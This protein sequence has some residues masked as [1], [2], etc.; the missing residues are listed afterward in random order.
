MEKKG[1]NELM[2]FG[3]TP[4][5]AVAVAFVIAVAISLLLLQSSVTTAHRTVRAEQSADSIAFHINQ[6]MAML[7]KQA[8]T[9][10]TSI[11]LTQLVTSGDGTAIA[12]EEARLRELIPSAL[13]V[14]LFPLG[15][16][17]LD[18]N[19]NPPFSF[20][21]LDMVNRV[22]TGQGVHP[23]AI[24]TNGS[25]ALSLA[26][27]IRSPSDETVRGTL[28][29]YLDMTALSAGLDSMSRGEIRLTQTFGNNPPNDI[30][31]TGDG[32]AGATLVT[33]VMNNP[34]WTLNYIPAERIASSTVGNIFLYL[35]PAIAFLLIAVAGVT[36]GI[37]TILRTVNA[38]AKHLANQM[39]DVISGEYK[40][41]NRYSLLSFADLDTNLSR[42]GKGQVKKPPVPKLDVKLQPKAKT[43]DEMV[44]IEMLDQDDYERETQSKD[45]KDS[46]GSKDNKDNAVDIREIFRAYDIRG[47]V[48][49]TLTTEVIKKI[50]LA[51]GSEA[52][53]LGE[54]ALVVGFDGRISSPDVVEALIEGLT[55]SGRDVINIGM[56]PTPVLYFAT[57]N[58]EARSGVMVTASHNPPDYNGFKIVLDGRTLVEDD[59]TRIYE[60]VMSGD[61]SSGDGRVRE[62]DVT[63]DY[64]EAIVDDVVVAQPLKVVVDCGNGVAGLLVPDLLNNLGCDVLPLY[65]DVDGHFPNHPADPL[66]PANLKDLIMMVKT[67]EAD[68]GIAFDG[69]GDRLV[70]I[71][72]SGEIVWPD[73]LMMLF[74]KDV[75]ARNPG[76][77]VV[78]DVK[79][80]RH[81]NTIISTFGGR[82]I[83]CRSGHSFLKAKMA[84]TDAVLGGEMSGHI[85][86]GERWFGFDDG[87]YAAARLLEIVGSQSLS[88]EQL[89][90]EFPVS[91]ATPEIQIKVPEAKKFDIIATLVRT[92]AFE[93]S[94]IT[95]IDGL[96][97]DFADGWGLVRAS[98]TGPNLTLR[99]EADDQASLVRI[100]EIFK[101]HLHSVDKTLNF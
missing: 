64:L 55:E 89:L 62:I 74:A 53:D 42:L 51:I 2:S 32:A 6:R 61:F 9:A 81:L 4:L 12:V 13:R 23:E 49:Q 79:C 71:T 15:T 16:A 88:L 73:R 8:G 19:A 97:V 76:S 14:R 40:P 26:V 59:I 93:E 69:D 67:E 83:I 68:L 56:V 96:R 91:L 18:R 44:D 10:A 11:L 47:V 90:A 24:N 21:S 46:K 65:C 27:P 95:E 82:P 28:F 87:M 48:D 98:N 100:Q 58:S 86:F 99:F 80:T 35:A 63:G 50:G 3:R 37:R 57:H 17:K 25:W 78:Y 84:E 33:R 5:M 1:K 39:A 30:V 45:T 77:D 92:A 38:D 31:K 101:D 70:A 34:I 41:S 60:R 22:E 43:M 94:T 20:T 75:V 66:V 52:G 54:Q 7:Q 29:V 72:G 85:C 36:F